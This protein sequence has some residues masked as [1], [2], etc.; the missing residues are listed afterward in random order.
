MERDRSIED[1][2]IMARRLALLFRCFCE[3]IDKEIGTNKGRELVKK[4][5]DRYGAICGE[6]A[7]K[8]VTKLGLKN[9]AENY[10]KGQDLPSIGWEFEIISSTEDNL[11]IKIKHCPLA[12]QWKEMGL[13]EYD[14]IYCNVDQAKYS[15][16]NDKLICEH[17]ENVL[18]GDESCMIRV[19][20]NK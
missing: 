10:S 13:N 4:V 20:I 3:E 9:T 17:V 19:T 15:S 16:Y 7:L 11:V 6:E 2:E 5:V 18:D 12:V 8:A 1:V 14:R